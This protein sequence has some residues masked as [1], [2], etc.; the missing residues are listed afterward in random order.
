MAIITGH[1]RVCKLIRQSSDTRDY[2]STIPIKATP[3][4]FSLAIPPALDQQALGS[5]AINATS[6][7]LRML[8]LTYN[9]S[10]LMLYYNT[11][12]GVELGNPNDD[13][14]VNLRDVFKAINTYYVAPENLWQY[15]TNN[16]SVLPPCSAYAGGKPFPVKYYAVNQSLDSIKSTLLTHPILAGIEVFDSFMTPTVASTGSVPLPNP[17]SERFLGGHCILIFGFDDATQTFKFQNSWGSTWGNNGCGTIGYYYVVG[18]L[19]L[20]FDLW[21][22]TK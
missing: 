7:N 5:C 10:R 12:V 11:R 22:I 9:P 15:F 14:G 13:S 18:V 4:K 2:K 17:I 3:T 1:K 6:N 8:G 21:V 19:N 16:F 20:C